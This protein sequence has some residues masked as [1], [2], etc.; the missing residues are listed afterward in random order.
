MA[1]R[2]GSK[3]RRPTGVGITSG[4]D[5]ESTKWTLVG[6]TCLAGRG[7][8]HGQLIV[9]ELSVLF[10]CIAMFSHPPS[11]GPGSRRFLKVSVIAGF[12]FVDS[13]SPEFLY[14]EILP[15]SVASAQLP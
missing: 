6:L 11:S 14:A 7:Q 1:F 4:V 15:D 12:F 9:H 2:P 5:L 3:G 13:P 10:V 8:R